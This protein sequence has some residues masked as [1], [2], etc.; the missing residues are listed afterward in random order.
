MPFGDMSFEVEFDFADHVVHIRTS[1][2]KHQRIPLFERSVSDFYHQYMAGLR[3]FGIDL[4]INTIPD[5]VEDRTPFDEDEHHASYDRD[6]VEAFHR[7]LT[8]TD[9]VFK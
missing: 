3:S 4:E 7:V 9:L 6:K 2:G 1:E 8:N 5:E